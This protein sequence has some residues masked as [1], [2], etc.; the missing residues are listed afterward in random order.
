VAMAIPRSETGFRAASGTKTLGNVS[1]AARYFFFR[2]C[3]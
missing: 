2:L 3:M 1:S